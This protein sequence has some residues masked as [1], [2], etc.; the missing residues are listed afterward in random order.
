MWNFE[1]ELDLPVCAHD[2]KVFIS[3]NLL[4]IMR[5]IHT[6]KYNKICGRQVFISYTFF[7]GGLVKIVEGANNTVHFAKKKYCYFHGTG[8]YDHFSICCKWQMSEVGPKE[9]RVR[10][11]GTIQTFLNVCNVNVIY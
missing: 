5:I 3:Q 9:G 1:F 4:F 11:T 10:H 2:K 8:L 6:R 7:R